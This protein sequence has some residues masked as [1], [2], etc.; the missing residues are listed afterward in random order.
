MTDSA[1]AMKA[2]RAGLICLEGYEHILDLQCV[3]Q[4][5]NTDLIV[6]AHRLR[7]PRF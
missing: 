3:T 1:A 7:H 4:P 5:P 2:A 6:P